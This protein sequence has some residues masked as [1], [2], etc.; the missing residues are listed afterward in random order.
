MRTIP[1]LRLQN[2]VRS[3][4]IAWMLA[5]VLALGLIPAVVLGGLFVNQSFKDIRFAEREVEGLDYLHALWPGYTLATDPRGIEAMQRRAHAIQPEFLNAATQFDDD[6]GTHEEA[7]A[8]ASSLA[9]AQRTGKMIGGD[10]TGKLMTK[11]GDKSNLILDPDLDTYYLMDIVL[12]KLRTLSD[13]LVQVRKA[14]D[15]HLAALTLRRATNGIGE[16]VELAIDGNGDGSLVKTQLRKRTIALTTA[17]DNYIRALEEGADAASGTGAIASARDALWGAAATELDRLLE[18][19]IERLRTKLY[20]SLA[21]SAAVVLLVVMLAS[22]LIR[23]LSRDMGSISQRLDALSAGDVT[24]HVPGIAL[25]NDIGVIA[26]ALRG[27]IAQAGER[28]AL[29]AELANAREAGRVALEE[30]VA[31]VNAENAK[32]VERVT[33]QQRANQDAERNAVASLAH[34][35]EARIAHVLAAARD[36]ARV[37]DEAAGSMAHVAEATQQQSGLATGAATEIRTVFDEAAPR[38]DAIARQLQTLRKQTDQ[39]KQL[40]DSAIARVDTASQRMVAFAEATDRIDEMQAMIAAV[41]RQTNLVAL[42]AGI[43]AMRVGAAGEGFMVVANEVKALA[44]STHQATA[45]IAE[46]IE[47]MREATRSVFDAFE[48]ILTAI[49]QVSSSARGISDGIAVQTD[50]MAVVET[51][52]NAAH[53]TVSAMTDSISNADQAARTA[54]ATSGG[55][56]ANCSTVVDQLA[57]LDSTLAVFTSGLKRAQSGS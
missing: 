16:S 26:R 23:S 6:F 51:T 49:G 40:A 48:A 36:S 50:S 47:G 15:V 5:M 4:P 44:N 18:A 22:M 45:S 31:R 55:I 57:T 29:A 56:A 54:R 13:E 53:A 33:E 28:E 8:V 21:S 39:G 34:E 20:L 2:I 10:A 38:V 42:N 3:I 19:R 35:L 27:F 30:T 37:M 24:S 25:Q 9:L 46:Q 1:L 12:L 11:I 32:L 43:E 41:A 14:P 52:M 17:T 7:R